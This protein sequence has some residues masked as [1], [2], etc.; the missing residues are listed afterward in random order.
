M[1]ASASNE[2]DS[3][4]WIDIKKKSIIKQAN[5]KAIHGWCEFGLMF[6]VQSATVTVKVKVGV[7]TVLR[8]PVFMFTL[9]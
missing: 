9:Y 2:H 3:V 5:Q 4:F 8:A 6:K 1:E 7:V